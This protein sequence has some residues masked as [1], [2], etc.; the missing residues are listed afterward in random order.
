MAGHTAKENAV[1]E[2][3]D[4]LDREA[5]RIL[6]AAVAADYSVV[7]T[8]D[9]G[10]CEELIEPVSGEPQTQHTLYPVPCLIVD[11]DKWRLSCSGG[12]SNVAPTVLQLMGLEK[13]YAMSGRSLL[14][15][16]IVA[17]KVNIELQ[18]AA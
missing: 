10:N 13:P 16:K 6:D 4:V 9:H 17:Q 18:G 14:P 8:A 11:Q 3:I 1:I 15:Q 7:L 5:G 2:A 12:L